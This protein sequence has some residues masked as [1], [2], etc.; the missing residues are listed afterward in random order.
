MRGV[1]KRKGT[2]WCFRTGLF[3]LAVALAASTSLAQ[4]AGRVWATGENSSGQLGIGEDTLTPGASLIEDVS[5]VAAGNIFSLA[6][7]SDGTVWT[8]G[9]NYEGQL[10]DGTTTNSPTPVQ[11]L[12]PGGSGYFTGAQA[13][14]GG[15]SHT[16]AIR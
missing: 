2:G 16:V 1:L 11:V 7:K 3:S 15:E 4:Q 9:R 10:G 8:W 5:A 13:I 6:L 14:A 12:G